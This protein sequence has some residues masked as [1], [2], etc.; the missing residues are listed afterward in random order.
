M[1]VTSVAL[2]P[3]KHTYRFPVDGKWRGDPECSLRVANPFGTQ[4]MVRE[5]A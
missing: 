1:W 5:A 4:D 3:G 2:E